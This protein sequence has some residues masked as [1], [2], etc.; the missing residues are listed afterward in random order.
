MEAQSSTAKRSRESEENEIGDQG[1]APTVKR[2]RATGHDGSIPLNS[3]TSHDSSFSQHVFSSLLTNQA[4]L[5][6][7]PVALDG[8]ACDISAEQV[9]KGEASK[10]HALR[11]C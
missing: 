1:V 10:H 11:F 6:L 5:T 7:L 4:P 8:N 2:R 3:F 9:P